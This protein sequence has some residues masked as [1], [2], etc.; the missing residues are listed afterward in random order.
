MGKWQNEVQCSVLKIV[1]ALGRGQGGGR[2][3]A[4][5]V[6]LWPHNVYDHAPL[7]MVQWKAAVAVCEEGPAPA[8]LHA[9]AQRLRAQRR[10]C[11]YLAARSEI[12]S[13]RGGN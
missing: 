9:L 5:T 4:H 3:E 12:L 1:R 10:H 11:W 13:V 6:C 2:E 8:L 7:V